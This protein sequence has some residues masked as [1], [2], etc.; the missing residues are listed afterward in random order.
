MRKEFADEVKEEVLILRMGA[1]HDITALF[2]GWISTSIA[3][4]EV[5]CDRGAAFL[6]RP[7]GNVGIQR[8]AKL[9]FG[10]CVCVASS[11]AKNLG[12]FYR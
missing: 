12:S 7:D 3:E 6:M 11:L 2:G 5:Q 4:L 10:D 8:S 1:N 9:F